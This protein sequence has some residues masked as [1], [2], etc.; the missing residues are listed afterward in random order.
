MA[1]AE[2]TL[3]SNTAT[4]D[5]A[6]TLSVTPTGQQENDWILL[7]VVSAG[8]TG[9]H[10]NTAGGLSR[11]TAADI[12]GGTV[13]VASTWK[14]KCGASESG[15]TYTFDFGGSTR[16]ACIIAIC[17]SGGDGTDIVES[18][19]AGVSSGA[20]ATS[21]A[22][23]GVDPADVGTVHVIWEFSRMAGG[24]TQSFTAPTNY[25]ELF[26]VLTAHATNANAA[27][28]VSTRALPDANATGDQTF[29]VSNNDRLTG[30]SVLL[31]P[32]SGTSVTVTP[33]AVATTAS[34]PAASVSAGV[35]L[36]PDAIATTASL[37]AASVSIGTTVTP[38]TIATTV[39]VPQA[40]PVTGGSVTVSPAT[41]AATVSVPAAAVSAG[42]TV[43]PSAIATSASLPAAS[44]SAG[45][46]V[47]PAAI[48]TTIGVPA[49][50]PAAH[51]TASPAV[52][53]ATIS[54]PAASLSA[55]ATVSPAAIGAV[56]A[57][58][59]TAVLGTVAKATSV[60]AVTATATSVPAVSATATSVPAVSAG[61]TST[62]TVG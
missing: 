20:S 47:T 45:S 56:V 33:S 11:A 50:S 12:A 10:S 29:T 17:Y 26:E 15:T 52:L 44:P 1:L 42:S 60:A 9:A 55:G 19:P 41:I 32:S 49:A 7:G 35:T 24:E 3:S 37:P 30:A 61:R 54:L 38:A 34:L 53:T 58:P 8:G 28:A 2:R 62:A 39:A 57:L 21:L 16:R 40:T 5:G 22:V 59:L 31:K 36:T 48:A 13:T 51:A 46:T 4:T 27:A 23:T 6:T 43:T 25:T 18:A 14:K